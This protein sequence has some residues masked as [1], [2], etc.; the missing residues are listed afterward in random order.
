MQQQVIR[1]PNCGSQN[2]VGQQFCGVCGTRLA[3]GGQQQVIRCPNCGSQ[4]AMGL[5]FCGACGARLAA[6]CPYC[7]AGVDP[8]SRFCPNCGAALGAGM[9]QQVGGMPQQAG[10]AP[11]AARSQAPSGSPVLI[12]LLVVILL[13]LGFFSYWAFASPSW[14]PSLFSGTTTTDTTPPIISSVS[15]STTTTTAAITW[16]TDELTGSQVEYGTDINYGTSTAWENDPTSGTSMGVVTHSVTLTGLTSGTEYHY[17]VKSKDAAGNVAVSPKNTFTTGTTNG[18]TTTDTTPPIIS[19]V[20]ASTTTTTA[21]ITWATDELAGSQVEYGTDIN[22]GT[23]TAWENDPTSGTSTGVATHSVT[24]T[25]LTSGTE[26]HYRVKSKDAAGN[27]A[28]SPDNTFTT[29]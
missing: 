5:Q 28:V 8:T 9:P 3:T 25:G 19:S 17:R 15:A 21:V 12:M 2:T 6:G 27:V 23:S 22:Y 10:W 7:G 29:G 1:C 13:G 4:N 26:Y 14:L 20:L 11:P 16:T 18:T 24:L